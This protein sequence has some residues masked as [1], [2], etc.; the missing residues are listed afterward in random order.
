MEDTTKEFIGITPASLFSIGG[1]VIVFIV[2]SLGLSMI[3]SNLLFILGLIMTS[4]GISINFKKNSK[5]RWQKT[6]MGFHIF[7]LVLIILVII[8]FNFLR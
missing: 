3:Y 8:Y 5:I 1:V 4:Y 6:N 7:F 2:V